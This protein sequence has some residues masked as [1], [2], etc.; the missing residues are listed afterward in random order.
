MRRNIS[1]LAVP[2]SI[3]MAIAFA[4]A[5][6]SSSSGGNGSGTGNGNGDDST[7]APSDAGVA[8]GFNKTC[9]PSQVC[10]YDNPLAPTCAAAGSCTAS[11]LTCSSKGTCGG[12]QVCCFT[13]EQDGGATDGGPLVGA[14]PTGFHSQCADTCPSTSYSLCKTSADCDDGGTC[15]PGAYA[16]FCG[17][18]PTRDGGYVYPDGGY[19]YP[20]RDA[21]A[22]DGGATGD[23]AGNGGD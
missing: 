17:T 22:G 9:A 13:Y 11:T 2:F 20:R 6:S 21:S 1:L 7:A 16:G 19:V 10:C 23:D 14:T 4:A 8:C 12:G 3:A 5:C 15:L 18:L